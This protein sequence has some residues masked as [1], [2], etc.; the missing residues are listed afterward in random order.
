[1]LHINTFINSPV[2]SNTFVLNWDETIGQCVV[3][4]PGT[5]DNSNIL[6]FMR[7]SKLVP[8]Y[9]IL[10]HEDFD[11]FWGCDDLQKRYGSKIICSRECAESISVPANYFNLFYYNDSS[12][13]YVD[14]VSKILE[15]S[16]ETINV[17]GHD[18]FFIKTPGHTNGSICIIVEDNMFVGDS[19][20]LVRDNLFVNKKH[21]G[22]IG[23][24]R[25]NI[26]TLLK[27]AVGKMIYPGHGNRFVIND[28]VL[29]IIR[30]KSL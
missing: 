18:F 11:H 2:S 21:G 9:I 30:E 19:I 23:V 4:D 10:T 12:E 26:N 7:E 16:Y 25:E 22:N 29:N 15:K 28:E 8:S 3:I 24:L 27:H 20:L 5:K 13:V 6:S 1:M 17:L 14:T